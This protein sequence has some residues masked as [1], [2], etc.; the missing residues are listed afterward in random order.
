MALHVLPHSLESPHTNN[1]CMQ[2]ALPPQSSDQSTVNNSLMKLPHP[3]ETAHADTWS[4]QLNPLQMQ[5]F[6]ER[7]GPT[8]TMPDTLSLGILSEVFTDE[9][10]DSI[11]LQSNLYASQ[12]MSEESFSNWHKISLEEL[13]AYF[14]FYVLMGIILL[15]SLDYWKLGS[16]FHYKPIAD[17]ITHWRF[18][19]ISCCLYFTNNFSLEKKVNLVMTNLAKLHL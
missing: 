17:R 14:G 13:K 15:P 12:V 9:F 4:S 18:R 2:Q 19:E 1:S 10:L 7:L 8:F 11:V 3:P 6:S 5:Q 16:V